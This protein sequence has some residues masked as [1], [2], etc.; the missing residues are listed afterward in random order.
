VRMAHGAN[1]T[2]RRK[3]RCASFRPALALLLAGLLPAVAAAAAASPPRYPFPQHVEAVPDSI[4]PSHRTQQQLDDDFRLLYQNWKSRYLAQAGSEP[5]GHPRYR[6][7]VGREATAYTVSEGQGYGMVIVA[8]LAGHDPE[9]R[10]LLDGLWEFSLDHPSEIDSRLMDW[11]VEADEEPD[12]E[13][14]DSAFDGDCS[15]ALGLLPAEKQWGNAGRFDYGAEAA[16]VM[17]GILASTVGPG[18][19]L[20]MLGDWV[21]P[22]GAVYSQYTPRPSDFMPH[23]FRSFRRESG[24][25]DWLEVIA[26]NAL[27][28]VQATYSPATGLVPDFL[29]LVSPEDPSLR[30]ASPGFLE[31]PND[32][33]YYYNSLRVPLWLGIDALFVG[34]PVSGSQ[35]RKISTWAFSAFGGDP[36]AIGAGFE[37]DGTPLPG[38]NYFTTAFAA[39]FG[40][41]AMIE[42]GQ[43]QWLDDLYDAVRLSDESY[44]EDSITLLCLL[45]MTGNYWS[46]AALPGRAPGAVPTLSAAGVLLL[47]VALAI[48]GA[49]VLCLHGTHE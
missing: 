21:D 39:P 37:L 32:G 7:K 40:V 36:G 24:L 9:A 8:L 43:Q 25:S 17:E 47:A 19:R 2:W 28:Q 42:P 49:R 6:V 48:P 35:L 45:V 31:G 3:L 44:Y 38:S 13:G 26:Q 14:N 29:E 4:A 16:R 33:F 20:P 23:A 18:S 5:D 1:E 46:P 10:T 15:L 34:D 22:D 27:A 12:P 11:R 30:P 41:A